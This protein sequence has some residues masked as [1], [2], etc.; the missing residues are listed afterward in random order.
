[1]INKNK[2]VTFF[3]LAVMMINSFLIL[4]VSAYDYTSLDYANWENWYDESPPSK[5][6]DNGVTHTATNKFLF[7]SPVTSTQTQYNIW[8]L[9]N[10]GDELADFVIT[11]PSSKV[12]TDS[13]VFIIDD[14]YIGIIFTT[15]PVAL[16]VGSV[17]VYKINMINYSYDYSTTNPFPANTDGTARG[18]IGNVVNGTDYYYVSIEQ[19]LSGFQ[20]FGTLKISKSTYAVSEVDED[21]SFCSSGNYMYTPYLVH[22]TD[23]LMWG[24]YYDESTFNALSYVLSGTTL[25]GIA[26]L[27]VSDLIA[28]YTNQYY[29]P[30]GGGY[31]TFNDTIVCY[32]Y[33]CDTE[34]L[35]YG[36]PSI[37]IVALRQSF[38]TTISTG[39]LLSNDVERIYISPT[40]EITDNNPI[41]ILSNFVDV[42][43]FEIWYPNIESETLVTRKASFSFDGSGALDLSTSLILD[44]D[45][46]DTTTTIVHLDTNDFIIRELSSGYEL[47]AN[48]SGTYLEVYYGLSPLAD[49]FTVTVTRTPSTSPLEQGVDYDIAVNVKN[50][51]INFQGA[52]VLYYVDDSLIQTSGTNSL[53]NSGIELQFSTTGYYTLRVKVLKDLIV[54]SVYDETFNYVVVESGE[55]EPTEDENIYIFGDTL[56]EAVINII[57]LAIIIL[58]PANY[59]GTKG[60]LMGFGIGAVIGVAVAVS[61]NMIPIY[62]VYLL[63][64]LI[65]MGFIFVL[66]SGGGATK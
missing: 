66:R 5:L 63:A 53:G 25:D 64:L 54:G 32:Y 39:T 48:P 17:V 62:Y 45:E 15:V 44:D 33:Y 30:I 40:T 23:S 11:L 50:N 21:L 14:N 13:R 28:S 35:G 2:I 22:I 49:D 46:L 27:P 41:W 65:I 4:S 3:L 34:S 51:L 1:M 20:Y 38:N 36:N 9:D 43:S 47:L 56:M 16:G 7:I 57:P 8:V 19:Q 52:I 42:E 31:E 58:L 10:E 18:Y 29:F 37:Q 24:I 59:G 61:S 60:G 26:T 6:I 12:A 55:E